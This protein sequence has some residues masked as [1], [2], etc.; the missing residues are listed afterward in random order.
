MWHFGSADCFT[1]GFIS[2]ACVLY[3]EAT[4][5]AP[6]ASLQSGEPSTANS[7]LSDKLGPFSGTS[8]ALLCTDQ[9]SG[10]LVMVVMLRGGGVLLWTC[11]QGF[12]SSTQANHQL[13]CLA[14]LITCLD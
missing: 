10:G 9:C 13:T 5:A 2:Y 12:P 3:I 1:I 7:T 8:S 11:P 4:S 6:R 14:Q